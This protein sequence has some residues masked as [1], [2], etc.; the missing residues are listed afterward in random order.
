MTTF[1]ID[2]PYP[3]PVRDVGFRVGDR[4]VT[5]WENVGTVT[6]VQEPSVFFRLDGEM[7]ERR[8]FYRYLTKI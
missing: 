1:A 4:V 6:R 7:Q 8:T 2:F 3:R 5:T